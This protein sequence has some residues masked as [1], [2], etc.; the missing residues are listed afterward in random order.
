MH[1]RRNIWS[2]ERGQVLILCAL[3]MIV[4]LLF[5]GLAIDFG[6]AYV[7]KAQIGKAADAAVLTAAR[8]SAQG[9]AKATALAQSAFAM[10]YGSSSLDYTSTPVVNVT[11]STDASGNTIVNVNATATNKTFFAGLLPGFSTLSVA[12]SA[13]S[14]AK[15]VVMTLVLDRTGSMVGDGGS[16]ALPPAV[17]NYIEL[18]NNSKDNVSVV[19]F[20]EDVKVDVP[21]MTGN[22][23]QPVINDVNAMHFAGGTF[24]D[25]GLQQALSIENGFV[26]PPGANYEK[27]VVFFTDGN[28]NSV[29]S[30]ATCKSGKLKTGVYNIGGYDDGSDVG[31]FTSYT[32]NE[33]CANCCN[34]TFTTL[35]GSQQ[36][37]NWTNVSGPS[38]DARARAIADANNMRA[39]GITVFAI[40]LGSATEPVDQPFLCQI[41]ND[42]CSTTYN[43]ALPS[44]EMEWAPN[45][46]ALDQAFQTVASTILLRLTQ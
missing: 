32:N 27:V 42:P 18:F 38:G 26:M 7:T 16:V 21:M 12:T 30:T 28:A 35:A 40:G 11:F 39:A 22:F 17:T 45:A 10:N 15:R 9:T 20:A 43:A 44:G 13:Q 46:E 5:V 23:Q 31:F 34:G 37:I 36:A 3:S 24:S 1:S 29:N 4:L 6:M 19:S 33:N 2:A 25:G 14:M 8:Y 41:A